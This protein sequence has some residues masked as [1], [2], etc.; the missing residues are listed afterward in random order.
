MIAVVEVVAVVLVEIVV[1]VDALVLVLDVVLVVLVVVLAVPQRVFVFLVLAL[2]FAVLLLLASHYLAR[3]SVRI[4]LV[5]VLVRILEAVDMWS[6]GA[7]LVHILGAVGMWSRGARAVFV[8][9]V[10]L[11][12]VVVGHSRA[13][14]PSPLQPRGQASIPC[15]PLVAPE[16]RLV[17]VSVYVSVSV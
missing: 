6:H 8:V 2:D 9:F 4:L 17:S 11:V 12:F 7:V 16:L 10:V 15:L 5:L 3:E 1:E 13:L 14:P